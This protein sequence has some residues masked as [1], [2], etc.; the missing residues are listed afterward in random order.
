MS[1]SKGSGQVYRGINLGNGVAYALDLIDENNWP[2]ASD[3]DVNYWGPESTLVT[4]EMVQIALEYLSL[5]S[6]YYSV[7]NQIYALAAAAQNQGGGGG[8]TTDPEQDE[9]L[10]ELPDLSF[11]APQLE[12]EPFKVP[13]PIEKK[14]KDAEKEIE[15]EPQA[16]LMD[17][18]AKQTDNNRS[19]AK[20]VHQNG[21]FVPTTLIT[22]F[23]EENTD[24]ETS[25]YREQER[26][27]R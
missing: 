20:N 21:T 16:L 8:Q 17:S 26:P 5:L 25:Q 3:E 7:L 9:F 13:D 1:D 23:F 22:P 12:I 24:G 18:F 14:S 4:N 19:F 10:A 6:T 27:G 2:S 15:R 11:D